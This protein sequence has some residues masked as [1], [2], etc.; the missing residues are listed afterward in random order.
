MCVQVGANRHIDKSGLW[1]THKVIPGGIDGTYPSPH[2]WICIHLSISYM[3]R[4]FGRCVW[5]HAHVYT[6]QHYH[7][8]VSLP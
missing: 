7:V 8:S 1:T 2:L 4:F 6:P 3:Y 5:L